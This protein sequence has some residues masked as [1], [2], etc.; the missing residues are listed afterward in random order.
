[1]KSSGVTLILSPHEDVIT[2]HLKESGFNTGQTNVI[3]FPALTYKVALRA[4]HNKLDLPE[5]SALLFASLM[6]PPVSGMDELIAD[7]SLSYVWLVDAK[8]ELTNTLTPVIHF[9]RMKQ[10]D[11]T[12]FV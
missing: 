10:S 12:L 3:F 5:S 1:M 4:L 9:Y 11:K 6:S 2:L 7:T 8:I